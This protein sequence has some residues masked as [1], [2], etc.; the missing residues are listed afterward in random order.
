[1]SWR[2][3]LWPSLRGPD[4]GTLRKV[5]QSL[6]SWSE[7]VATWRTVDWGNSGSALT[8]DLESGSHHV[9]NLTAAPCALTLT[10]PTDPPLTRR[11]LLSF[12]QG[13]ASRTVTWPSNARWSYG[14]PPTLATTSGQV[15]VFEWATFGD[16]NIYLRWY[17]MEYTP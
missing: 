3:T 10:V 14:T 4:G 13:S 5:F 12:K 17:A 1:M 7:G 15:D 6:A 9:V 2:N 16:G 8:I 11:G